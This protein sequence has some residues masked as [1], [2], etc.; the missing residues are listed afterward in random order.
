[1]PRRCIGPVEDAHEAGL[2]CG[3]GGGLRHLPLRVHLPDVD[4][5]TKRANQKQAQ[6]HNHEDDGLTIAGS[7]L[8]GGK[9]Q[10]WMIPCDVLPS[11][12][13]AGKNVTNGL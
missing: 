3:I 8:D 9:S 10:N 4:R 5:E 1:M 11:R 6:Y 2:T 12:S 13:V 7:V